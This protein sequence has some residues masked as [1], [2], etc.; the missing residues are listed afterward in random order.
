[1]LSYGDFLIFNLEIV[2]NFAPNANALNTIGCSYRGISLKSVQ[3]FGRLIGVFGYGLGCLLEFFRV[4]VDQESC[5]DFGL[6]ELVM[7]F[8]PNLFISEEVVIE[9][10]RS[11]K[12]FV[13]DL[14]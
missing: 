9:T 2:T 5:H 13:K 7:S 3:L 6:D 8:S 10:V 4:Q 11:G 14:R 12:E 1:M